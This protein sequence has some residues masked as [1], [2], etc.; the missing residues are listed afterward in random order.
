MQA[1]P[2]GLLSLPT[3]L[4]LYLAE[5]VDTWFDGRSGLSSLSLVCRALRYPAQSRLLS[6]VHID[7]DSQ[8]AFVEYILSS[9]SDPYRPR[10]HRLVLCPRKRWSLMDLSP[11]IDYLSEVD[12]IVIENNLA[13]V[14]EI[15]APSF[16]L[17]LQRLPRLSKLLLK[18]YRGPVSDPRHEQFLDLVS[19]LPLT[20]FGLNFGAQIPRTGG[21]WSTTASSLHLKKC[22]ID[23]IICLKVFAPNL[24]FLDL[25][26][27]DTLLYLGGLRHLHQLVGLRVQ[28][29]SHAACASVA[30]LM[31][32]EANV[33]TLCI[34]EVSLHDAPNLPEDRLPSTVENYVLHGRGISG[35]SNGAQTGAWVGQVSRYPG[36]KRIVLPGVED[37]KHSRHYYESHLKEGVRLDCVPWLDVD[38]QAL[39]DQGALRPQWGV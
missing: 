34:G 11:C 25:D 35:I 29:G 4:H 33:K 37:T 38:L 28:E 27:P 9:A 15:L 22:S 18:T 17:D 21:D 12:T 31:D 19:R 7:Q 26:F 14:T 32:V 39:S 24:R 5:W 8:A 10:P 1:V 36:V 3:E 13:T 30:D 20:T 2:K 6:S 16:F 23:T